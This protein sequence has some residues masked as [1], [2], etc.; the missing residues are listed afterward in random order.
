MTADEA[1][2]VSR[3]DIWRALCMRLDDAQPS[4]GVKQ[5][6]DLILPCISDF[7]RSSVENYSQLGLEPQRPVR[8]LL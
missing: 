8:E 6:I 3:A 2:L 7:I 4:R 1:G 5:G